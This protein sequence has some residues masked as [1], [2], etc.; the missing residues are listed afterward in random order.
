[1]DPALL[2]RQCSSVPASVWACPPLHCVRRCRR[3]HE[4]AANRRAVAAQAVNQAVVFNRFDGTDPLS[5][6]QV[7]NLVMPMPGPDEVL[8]R[9]TLR[10]VH[11]ADVS[12][13]KGYVANPSAFKFP[14]VLGIEGVG[15]VARVGTAVKNLKVGDRVVT[16]GGYKTEHWQQYVVRR[17]TEVFVV[18]DDVTEESAAQLFVN[19]LTAVGMLDVLN[20]PPGGYL[21]QTAATSCL[22]RIV[23][24]LAKHR[25]I[26]VINVVSRPEAVAELEAKGAQHVVLSGTGDLM[27]QVLEATNG[28]KADAAIDALAGVSTTEVATVVKDKGTVLV[29]GAVTSRKMQLGV[30]DIVVR[31]VGLKGFTLP[32]WRAEHPE[33]AR[34]EFKKLVSQVDKV[35]SP[36]SGERFV[37]GDAKE[38]ILASE[39]RARGGKILLEG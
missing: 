35:F 1:M 30:Y 4:S 15:E 19:P 39:M 29:Y 22:A 10:P 34:E 14:E 23:E 2:W 3:V 8:V 27:L 28:R 11:P 25:G 6:I 5:Q 36:C 26:S 33:R 37:L 32:R 16:M 18:P 13:V 17:G 38:A 21:L 20:I 7:V 12:V 31:D 9:M 24:D